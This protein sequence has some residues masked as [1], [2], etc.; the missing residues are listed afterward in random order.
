[1]LISYAQFSL[2]L[3]SLDISFLAACL[4]PFLLAA[5]VLLPSRPRVG[6]VTT[7]I[8]AALPLFWIYRAESRAFMN[9]WVLLNASEGREETVFLRYAQL[10]II[11]A[12]LLLL[13][14]ATALI[15]SLPPRWHVREMPVN[16]RTWPAFIVAFLVIAWW[17]AASAF[18]YRQPVILD[19]MAPELSVLHVEK[20]GLDFH[21]TRVSVYRDGRFLM[22]HNDR[23]LF[24][25][26]FEEEWHEGTLTDSQAT[27]LKTLLALPD[28]Q[29]TED[30][31]PRALRVMHGDGWYTEMGRFAIAAFTTENA[32]APPAELL[33]FFRG[34]I[35][36][37]N[38]GPLYYYEVRDVCLGF[39]YDPQA[40]LGYRALNQRCRYGTDNREY[41]Y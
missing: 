5:T 39:C 40:G 22:T 28:L 31:A 23:H 2:P 35:E 15:S 16:R 34:A 1:M 21:E 14:V 27:Q 6:H 12:A 10:R 13:A 11:W 17:F 20:N 33:A 38:K 25:Y 30:R 8:G 41:R 9:T 32:T 19:A 29:R 18:P 24:R 36:I 7:A 4:G 37:P 26:R 3:G